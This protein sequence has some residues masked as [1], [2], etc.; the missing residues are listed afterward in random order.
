MRNEICKM[1]IYRV[2]DNIKWRRPAK[3][4]QYLPMSMIWIEMGESAISTVSRWQLNR[5]KRTIW[6]Y[7]VLKPAIV[8]C[9]WCICQ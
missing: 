4:R 6:A 5:L 7:R 2:H 9:E 1:V 8:N 3:W